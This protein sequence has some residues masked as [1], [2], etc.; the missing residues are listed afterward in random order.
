MN[1]KTI[2]YNQD[3]KIFFLLPP[4]F[5]TIVGDKKIS[6]LRGEIKYVNIDHL[7]LFISTHEQVLDYLKQTWNETV[8]NAKTAW[9]E[10]HQFA[11]LTGNEK[12][13]VLDF[14]KAFQEA[15]SKAGVEL[16]RADFKIPDIESLFSSEEQT[17]MV[18]TIS[19]LL[20]GIIGDVTADMPQ[21]EE[22]LE[23]WAEDLNQKF[24]S[25]KLEQKEQERN[26]ETRSS[27]R[28]SIAQRL[29]EHGVTPSA[30]FK[31]K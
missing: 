27:V 23:A 2:W 25:E 28:D 15:F 3:V 10:L 21:K 22:D 31:K 11:Q 12:P 13:P 26:K 30:D 16:G 6:D 7:D 4:K 19:G 1:T 29:R 18:Q 9:L 20:K 14:G 17:E 8:Q 24:F 5:I